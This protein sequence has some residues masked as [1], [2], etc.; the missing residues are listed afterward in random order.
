MPCL[1]NRHH[2]F[3]T[4][5]LHQKSLNK[6]RQKKV[7]LRLK[8]QEQGKTLCQ[9]ESGTSARFERHGLLFKLQTVISDR[10]EFEPRQVNESLCETSIINS[11]SCHGTEASPS[12]RLQGLRVKPAEATGVRDWDSLVTAK[13]SGQSGNSQVRV[14]S[15][16]NVSKLT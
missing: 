10:S 12:E 3:K 1:W 9:T 16:N 6:P 5:T 13:R 7:P 15:T 2:M 4:N 14:S 11:A 8:T